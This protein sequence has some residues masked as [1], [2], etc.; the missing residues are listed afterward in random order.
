[1]KDYQNFR[2][3]Y[4]SKEKIWQLAEDFRATWWPENTIPV[5]METIVEKRIKLSIE[6]H[7]NLFMDH[8]IDAFLKS[9]ATGIVVDLNHYMEERF[10]KRMR[11][12]YAHEI[13]HYQLHRGLYADLEITTIDDWRLFISSVPD[14]EYR[15]VEWQANEFAGRL[16]VPR[17]MLVE[18]IGS[19]KTTLAKNGRI[20]LLK[21]DPGMVLESVSTYI[22]KPFDVSAE[23][24]KI[25]VERESLWP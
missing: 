10:R 20:D 22:A 9:D 12:S 24:I 7:P 18:Q 23:V 2:C 4:D 1:M 8:D 17:N 5:D 14:R 13:G 21:R 3:P 25:R 11:F 19:V 6:P 15:F 16:L